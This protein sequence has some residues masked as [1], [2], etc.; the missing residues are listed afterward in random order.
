MKGLTLRVWS[1]GDLPLLR[2]ANSAEMTAHLNGP[3][4]EEQVAD[5]HRRYLRLTESGEAWMFVV[6]AAGAPVGTIGCW[7][8]QW[9]DERALESGWFVLPEAQGRGVAS[10]ALALVIDRARLRWP[11][12]RY[13]TAFPAVSNAA[14]NGVCRRNGFTAVGT[15]SGTFRGGE[16]TMNEWALDLIDDGAS[17]P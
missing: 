16:L 10:T 12:R 7:P 9:R 4:T 11:D 8:T 2:A 6:E 15:I 1:S 5:R 3:E 13:L 17:F 14:S